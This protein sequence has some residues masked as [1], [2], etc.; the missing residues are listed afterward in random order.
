MFFLIK[1]MVLSPPRSEGERE[2]YMALR[3]NGGEF[4]GRGAI[5]SSKRDSCDVCTLV[6]GGIHKHLFPAKMYFRHIYEERVGY[7]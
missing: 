6:R 7:L 4:G 1:M 2:G 5:F 3:E